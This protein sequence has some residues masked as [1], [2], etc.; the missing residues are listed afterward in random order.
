M[1][2]LQA[3]TDLSERTGGCRLAVSGSLST[4][5]FRSVSLLLAWVSL[6]VVAIGAEPSRTETPSEGAAPIH[7]QRHDEASA[8]FHRGRE[9]EKLGRPDAAL[10][11]FDRVVDEYPEAHCH[12]QALLGAARLR[13]ELDQDREASRL[14][15][16][17]AEDYPEAPQFDEVLFRWASVEFDLGNVSRSNELLQRLCRE[18]PRSAYG[19]EAAYRLAQRAFEANDPSRAGE[20]A[21]GLLENK[22][23]KD[24]HQQVLF[25]RGR[26]A[27]AQ[28]DWQ[29]VAQRF[30]ELVDQFPQ[31]P[32]RGE[33]R[34]WIAESA[35]RL[36][37]FESASRQFGQ[38]SRR[39]PGQLEPLAAL[40]ALRRAQVFAHRGKWS[41]AY[42]MAAKIPERFPDFKQCYE[43]RYLSGRCLVGRCELDAAREAFRQ[44]IDSPDGSATET[45]AMAQWMIGQTYLDEENYALAAGHYRRMGGDCAFAAWRAAA[46]LQAG[47]CYER[48]DKWEDAWQMYTRLMEG[49]PNTDFARRAASRLRTASRT[50]I[51]IAQPR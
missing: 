37:D 36:G 12:G 42:S 19:A 46:L 33:A 31:S 3:R 15:E 47:N 32:L 13:D 43:A 5:A 9:F 51:S 6:A 30:A 45:A 8:T 10:L 40:I 23:A 44:V 21:S 2:R 4:S 49:Y 48:L 17:L 18:H 24:I 28:E 20:L 38:L 22:L 7:A 35:F 26:I 1:T 11:L 27:V 29:Q 34:F 14:Y 50:P 41:E 25:L 39:P 16:R